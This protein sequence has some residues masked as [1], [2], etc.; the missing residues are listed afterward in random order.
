MLTK[1]TSAYTYRDREKEFRKFFSQ[2][3][4]L[5]Y[6]SDVKGLIDELKPNAYK[7]E[8]WRLFIDS[9]KRSFKAVLLHNGNRYAPIPVAH[10]TKLKEK[11]ENLVYVLEK[12]K[13]AEHRWQICGDLKIST[14]ILGQQSGFTKHPCFLCL[15]DSRDRENHYKKKVWEKRTEHKPGLKNVIHDPLVEPSKVLIPP[16]H[17]KLGMMTQF[18]KALDKE[19]DCFQYLEEK[20][21]EISDAKLQAGVFD[22]PHIR[23][24]FR[25]EKFVTKMTST[26]KAAWLSFKDVAQNFLGNH[27][28]ENYKTLVNKLLKNYQKLGCLMNLKLHFLHSHLDYFPEN[29]GDYSEEQ[30]E[31]FHQDLKEMERRYQGKWDINMMADFCWMLKREASTAGTKRKRNPLH[32]SFENKRVRYNRKSE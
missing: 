10:S 7:A 8:E 6:C 21:P 15:W 22:G 14:M 18:V 19:G 23:T 29:L 4:K 12:I 17:L 24:L 3:E 20:F 28:S 27:K 2:D 16:L 13:Y 9:S 31:R 25:D 1:G 26:Q 30:G 32:R 5:V 11:Y